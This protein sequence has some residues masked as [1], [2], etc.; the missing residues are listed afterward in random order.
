VHQRER[1]EDFGIHTNENHLSTN[2]T[3][4]FEICVGHPMLY[5]WTL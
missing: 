5:W 2:L 1:Y 4:I 3:A